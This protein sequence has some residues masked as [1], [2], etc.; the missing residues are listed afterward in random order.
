MET[1]EEF[2]A[3]Q[4]DRIGSTLFGDGGLEIGEVR[5][6]GVSP[7]SNLVP[8]FRLDDIRPGGPTKKMEGLSQRQARQILCRIGPE[9]ATE[10][11]ALMQGRGTVEGD[12]RE[13][14][15]ALWLDEQGARISS[16]PSARR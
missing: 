8:E 6:K 5:P 11:L 9:H 12:V 1:L 14:C 2:T 15:K 3:I 13:Q 16:G 4:R 7:D 10:L